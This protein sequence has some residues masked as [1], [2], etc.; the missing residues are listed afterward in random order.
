ME[1]ITDII[2]PA[3]LTG[4]VQALTTG[5]LPFAAVPPVIGVDTPSPGFGSTAA[6]L[7]NLFPV[8]QTDDIE[9][10]LVNSDMTGSGE[11]ARYR[12]WD[13]KPK[14]GKRP[15][16]TTIEGEIVPLDWSYRLNEK[17]LQRYARF[18]DALSGGAAA[19]GRDTRVVDV[20]TA[21]AVRAAGAVHNR[22][23][24]AHAEILSAGTMT[25]TELGDPE[26]GNA[27]A[28]TFPVP[29]SHFAAASVPW[30]TLATADAVTDLKAAEEIY[31]DDNNGDVPEEWW[32]SRTVAAELLQHTKLLNKLV[33]A[34]GASNAA[35]LPNMEIL[36]QVLRVHGVEAPIRV[37]DVKRPP[38]A[39]GGRSSVLQARKVIGVRAG[40]GRTLFTPPASASLMPADARIEA[41]NQAGVIAYSQ[42]DVRPAEVVTTAEA[43]SVP[44]LSNPNALFVL[45]V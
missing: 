26:T 21:D 36:N 19:A 5:G 7:P 40:M 18:R 41:Q 6:G 3:R 38:L 12:S 44:V 27:L 24:L 28:A 45:S 13:T 17:D 43:V 20:L 32:I 8:Q 9:Y 22:I 39:G 42:S 37:V 30:S 4:T 1:F 25:L 34:V 2:T 15:S 29:A 23:T 16:I 10:E 11:V 33:F 14:I 31:A 35:G